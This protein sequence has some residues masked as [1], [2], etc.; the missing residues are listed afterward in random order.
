MLVDK[1]THREDS[2]FRKAFAAAGGV[3]VGTT[4]FVAY[5]SG[6][7]PMTYVPNVL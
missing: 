1:V 7:W 6:I 2:K 3:A 4:A 5:R